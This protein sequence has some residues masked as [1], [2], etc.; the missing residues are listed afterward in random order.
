[1]GKGAEHIYDHG[2]NSIITTV[3]GIMPFAGSTGPCRRII[4]WGGKA[5]VPDAEN[6]N[7]VINIAM[8]RSSHGIAAR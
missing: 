8:P 7:A 6:R 1:M 2:I 3:N 4:S 5:D